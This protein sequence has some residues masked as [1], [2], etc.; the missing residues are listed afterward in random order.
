MNPHI[1]LDL[2]R[3]MW[4]AARFA[5]TG[6]DRVELAYARHLIATARD[7]LSFAGW[8]GRLSLLPGEDAIAMIAALDAMWSGSAVDIDAR[9]TVQT[10]IRKL[11]RHVLL[12]GEAPLHRHLTAI[13]K[14]I[15]Y[16]LVSHYR[17][18]RPDGLERLKRHSGVR[19]VMLVH[20]LIPIQHPE[21]MPSWQARRHPQ[22]MNAVGR[23]A[24]AVIVNS[25]GT[26]E[27]LQRYLARHGAALPI[28]VAPLGIDLALPRDVRA[29]AA[30]T[31]YF[32]YVATIE[33]RKNHAVL[34]EAWREVR[35]VFGAAAPKLVLVGRR[36]F[37]SGEILETMRSAEWMR[38]VIEQHNRLPDAA[39][40]RLVSGACASVYSSVAE[41]F[42]LPVA[43]A[44]ALGVP[45]LCSDVAE[46]R[47][48]GRNVPEYLDPR[49]PAAWARAIT[50]YARP[51]STGRRTQLE[52]L[53]SWKPPTWSDHFRLVQPLI[54]GAA[55]RSLTTAQSLVAG[56][57][58]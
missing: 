40:A 24:D 42:G 23:L 26:G 39:V 41:G 4:R 25:A 37:K 12:R 13:R 22:R 6:I 14:P 57:A 11:H 19:V 58:S 33:P 9:D 55:S 10:L 8:W 27:A 47:E 31:P 15:V 35:K 34:I 29:E 56:A 18:H 21:Q 50:D 16:L 38:G 51:G 20:D 7:R 46:L 54:D 45:V 28:V 32:T 36:G 49:D 52:R 44:L 53:K 17:L 2:S 30:T 1:V 5:P 3:L 43:E 48:V